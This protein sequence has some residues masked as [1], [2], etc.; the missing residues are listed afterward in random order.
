MNILKPTHFLALICSAALLA[1]NVSVAA[2]QVTENFDFKPGQL[3]KLDFS[4]GGSIK[5]EGWDQAGIEV[6]YGDEDNSLDA[7]DI[8]F[9]NNADGLSVSA[10]TRPST[11]HTNL[12]FKFKAPREMVL[13]FY[14]AGG[15]VELNG[16]TGQFK[17]KTAGGALR[18]DDVTGDLDLSTGGGRIL[19]QNSTVDG[20][21]RTGGGKVLV[22]NVTGDLEASSGGGTVTYKKFYSSDGE[23]LSPN[24]TKLDDASEETVLISNQGGTI[25]VAVAPEGAD[26]YTGGGKIRIQ[27]ANRFVAARTG[28]GDIDIDILE[29]WVNANTGAGD[30]EVF[31]VQNT[32]EK[33]DISLNSGNGDIV[34]TL[35]SDFSM[36]LSVE[37]GVTNNTSGNYSVSSDFDIDIATDDEWD[38][39]HGTPRKYT[40]GSATLNGG[41]HRVNIHTT[42]GNVI[43]KKTD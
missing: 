34:L 39:S 42:N 20:E 4:G 12:D 29:G 13:D 15:G 36:D 24:K 7:Y 35:P 28:G 2:D 32:M 1:T 21:V 27:G 6:T 5:I 22:E 38:Y 33:G 31:V 16:L 9:E 8:R 3:L 17:G 43:I 41:D 37:L 25:D 26:V 10:D 40:I 14:T 18:I 19:V 11:N 30:I 23:I